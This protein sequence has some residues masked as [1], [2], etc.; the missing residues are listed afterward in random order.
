MKHRDFEDARFPGMETNPIEHEDEIEFPLS[1][2]WLIVAL[3]F[4]FAVAVI[5]SAMS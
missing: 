5:T 1:K 4:V 2:R 3:A